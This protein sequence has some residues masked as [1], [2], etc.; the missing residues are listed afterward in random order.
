MRRQELGSRTLHGSTPHTA[1]PQVSPFGR[2]LQ[3]IC[4]TLQGPASPPRFRNR[5]QPG[6]TDL[7]HCRLGSAAWAGGKDVSPAPDLELAGMPTSKKR[8]E[9]IR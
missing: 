3:G 5:A 2:T 9:T 1:G 4:R 6:S 8:K 7:R